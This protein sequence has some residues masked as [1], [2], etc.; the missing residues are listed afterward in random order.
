M[1]LLAEP[2]TAR[3]LLIENL[4][5][6]ESA[7]LGIV[8]DFGGFVK[9]VF[10][11]RAAVCN[12]QRWRIENAGLREHL[13]HV[14]VK[15]DDGQAVL[16]AAEAVGGVRQIELAFGGGHDA[17]LAAG[18][19]HPL[20]L[21]AVPDYV[22]FQGVSTI[23]LLVLRNDLAGLVGGLKIRVGEYAGAGAISART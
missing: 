12:Q 1:L 16:V 18:L 4:M 3:A 8:V 21:L 5:R 20:A 13:D 2:G 10:R 6:N 9:I 15:R 14:F 23:V 11:P 22:R 17:H 7:Q 19:D